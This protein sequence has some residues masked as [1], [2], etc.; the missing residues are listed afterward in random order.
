[1]C[2]DVKMLRVALLS[3]T[4]ADMGKIDDFEKSMAKFRAVTE[5]VQNK[6]SQALP[7]VP[8]VEDMK[9]KDKNPKKQAEV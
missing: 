1:M 4:V 6:L 5:E 7:F 9:N 2:V 3:A 8:S